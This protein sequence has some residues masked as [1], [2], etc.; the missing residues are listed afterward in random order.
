MLPQALLLLIMVVVVGVV[1]VMG[2]VVMGAMLMY[3]L[4][5][6]LLL[7]VMSLCHQRNHDCNRD[8]DGSP[9]HNNVPHGSCWVLEVGVSRLEVRW[10]VL[11]RVSLLLFELCYGANSTIRNVLC[12]VRNVL[13]QSCATM[14]EEIMKTQHFIAHTTIIYTTQYPQY[15]RHYKKEIAVTAVHTAHR[16]IQQP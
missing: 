10:R 6:P 15:T 5:H 12:T 2:V 3:M 7:M 9:C 4:V 11:V 1:V 14:N 13:R 16:A 8:S